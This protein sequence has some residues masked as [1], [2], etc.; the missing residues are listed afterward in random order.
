MKKIWAP[1]RIQ[2]IEKAGRM[3]GCILCD[4]PAEKNDEINLILYRGRKNFVILNAYPYT[5]G[6]LM[7]APYRH[8]G[9]LNDIS[10]EESREHNEVIKLCLNLLNTTVKPDGF[11]IGMNLGRVAGAG[12]LGHVHTHI[13]PRWQGD[14]NFMPVV[15]DVKVL[16]EGLSAT[17]KKLKDGLQQLQK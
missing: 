13:V 8:V 15:A 3:E 16:S 11:N 6:H 7:V 17:Y 1:W 2:Y 14:N 10:E 9:D 12:V 5:P 4:K